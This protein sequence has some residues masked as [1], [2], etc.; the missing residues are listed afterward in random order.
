MT[1]ATLCTAIAASALLACGGH[2]PVPAT[3]PPSQPA[4]DPD[5]V[6]RIDPPAAHARVQAGQ[7]LLVCAYDEARCA[8]LHLEGAITWSALQD[9]LPELARDQEIILYCN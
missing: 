5:T 6:E 4:I 7:A 8:Q 3:P 2:E 1:T 9:R